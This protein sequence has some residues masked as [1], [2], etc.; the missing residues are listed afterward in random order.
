MTIEDLLTFRM[1]FGTITEPSMDPRWPIVEAW[2]QRD[3][4]LGPPDPRTPHEPDEWIR[5]FAELPLMCRPG[6]R[7]QYNVGTL[8]LGVL[9]A[10][11]AGRPLGDLLRERIFE[12]LGMTDTGFWLPAEKAARLPA[13]YFRGSEVRGTGPRTWISPPAFPSGS[14]GLVSTVDDFLTFGR[15]LLDGGVHGGTRLLSEKSVDL[16]THNHLTDEQVAGAGTLLGGSGWGLGVGVTVT[17]D[18]ISG[19]GRYGW[20]GGYGTTWFNDP[21]ERLVAIAMTQVSEF[22][23]NGAQ[24]EFSELAY[25]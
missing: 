19:P 4:V 25:R 2:E 6:T 10:R 9:L 21:G 1:G 8:V 7:W 23:W 11:A 14:A 20:S 17:A 24:T 12:P 15:M 13:Y 22:L 16:M 18:E 3:L 5:L